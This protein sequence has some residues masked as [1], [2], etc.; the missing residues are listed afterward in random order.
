MDTNGVDKQQFRKPL[1]VC[2]GHAIFIITQMFLSKRD[3]RQLA[4]VISGRPEQS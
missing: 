4:A 3:N 2:Q 1:H